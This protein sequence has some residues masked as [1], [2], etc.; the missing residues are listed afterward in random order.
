[1]NGDPTVMEIDLGRVENRSSFSFEGT[2]PLPTPEGGEA[3][4]T[5]AVTAEVARFMEHYDVAVTVGG[6]LRA[7][8]HR[9]LASF[10][11]PIHA[12]FVFALNRGERDQLSGGAEEDDLETIPAAG[13]TRYD[14]FPRVREALI[15]EIPIKLLCEE[16]CRGVC[17][18]C[19]A[20]LNTEECT[21][22]SSPGDPRWSALRKLTDGERDT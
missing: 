18:T 21:C 19:G 14:I 17:P 20:N 11:M 13:E 2:F 5:A 3:S 12:S 4:C 16:G 15:L 1:M 9:C 8:C 6:E 10:A 7:E 22:A